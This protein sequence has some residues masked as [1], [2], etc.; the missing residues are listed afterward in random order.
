MSAEDRAEA[1]RLTE[2]IKKTLVA[3]EEFNKFRGPDVAGRNR[4][5]WTTLL[6]QPLPE[7]GVGL[8]QVLGELTGTV[9]PHGLRTGSPGFSGYVTTAPTTGSVAARL[10]A[11]VAGSQRYCIQPFNLLE[12][13]ALQWLADLLGV[14]RD[15]QGILVSGG[16]VANLIGLGAARQK[17]YERLGKDPAQDGLTSGERCRIYASREVHHVVKR[18]A[19]VLGLGRSSVTDIAV[20]GDFRMDTAELRKALET[21]R[22]E[23]IL[24]VAIVATAGTINTGAVDPI[25]EMADLASEFETW[26]HVDGAYGLFGILDSRIATLFRGLA[27]ADSVVVDPH[28]WLATPVGIGAAYVRDRD[29]LTRA[30]SMGQA[31]YLTI[32]SGEEV[33]SAFDGLG[34]TYNE[35][36]VELSAPSRGVQVWAVLKEIGAEGIR[37][38]VVRHNDFAR[39]LA[40]RV[41]EDQHLELLNRPVLSICCLRYAPPGVG[42]D[43]LDELNVEIARLLRADAKFVPSTTRIAGKF[44]I[45]PC[46]INPRTSIAEVD[47]LADEVRRIGDSL[48]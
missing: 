28:K 3:L 7:Q 42:E 23:G 26:F 11:T 43:R 44:A 18:A 1:G 15:L 35:L 27:S 46:Y 17:A 22:S 5:V 36:G 31:E 48:I 6:N 40:F 37:E 21:D 30:F 45:R 10:A 8:D 12:G 33:L 16:A 19:A 32:P 4:V 2:A 38:R 24:P 9:I 41:V 14:S 20:D 13:V 34:D 39:H 29:L 47:G 25:Q